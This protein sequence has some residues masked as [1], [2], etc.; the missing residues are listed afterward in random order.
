MSLSITKLHSD[1]GVAHMAK[2][3]ETFLEMETALQD[4]GSMESVTPILRLYQWR[5]PTISL[6]RGQTAAVAL[7]PRWESWSQD[8]GSDPLGPSAVVQRPTGGRWFRRPAKKS[9][10]PRRRGCP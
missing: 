9:P 3:L 10:S 8:P 1:V 7:A 2:D 5:E 6:G 4:G